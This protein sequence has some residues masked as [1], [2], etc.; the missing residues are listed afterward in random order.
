VLKSSDDQMQLVNDYWRGNNPTIWEPG[1]DPPSSLVDPLFEPVNPA[2]DS[3]FPAT[4][5]M[6]K[7]Q[8]FGDFNNGWGWRKAVCS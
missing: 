6:D 1:S 8:F 7:T 4:L 3:G 5:G 2:D